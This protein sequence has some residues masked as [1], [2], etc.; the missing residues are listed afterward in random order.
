METKLQNRPAVSQDPVV[1][2]DS[3][4]ISVNSADLLATQRKVGAGFA[5]PAMGQ[6]TPSQT[7]TPAELQEIV[8]NARD[9][10]I[11]EKRAA[12]TGVAAGAPESVAG[13]SS[14]PDSSL[15]QNSIR[16]SVSIAG[17]KSV[18]GPVSV[19][20]PRSVSGPVSQK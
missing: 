1:S 5:L 14:V 11:A 15:T 10:F 16:G 8:K 19:S 7:R 17:P 3:S 18:S 4:Q 9:N 20:G 13:P 6:F 2:P 12:W